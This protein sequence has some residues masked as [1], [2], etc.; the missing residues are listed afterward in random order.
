MATARPCDSLE[1]HSKYF[2]QIET[3]EF[4]GI[5]DRSSSE[6]RLSMNKFGN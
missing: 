5:L 4:I 6:M 2:R 1:R 3:E